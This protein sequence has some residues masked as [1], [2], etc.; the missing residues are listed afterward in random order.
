MPFVE[1]VFQYERIILTLKDQKKTWFI[2]FI[3][4]KTIENS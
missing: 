1:N 3:N 4:S 2:D